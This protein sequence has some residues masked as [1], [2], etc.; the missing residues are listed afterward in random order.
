MFYL[1]NL[2]SF[3][4]IFLCWILLNIKKIFLNNLICLFFMSVINMLLYGVDVFVVMYV[5]RCIFS[6]DVFFVGRLMLMKILEFSLSFCGVLRL[7]SVCLNW[8]VLYCCI[9]IFKCLNCFLYIFICCLIGW[10]E[11]MVIFV[12]G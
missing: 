3:G 2:V 8:F 5:L 12:F 10:Y 9:F 1:M 11:D 7:L 4:N 6:L